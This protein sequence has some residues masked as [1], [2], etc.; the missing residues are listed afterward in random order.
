MSK[1]GLTLEIERK[2]LIRYPDINRLDAL[3]FKKSEI[4]QTY[5]VDEDEASS[6]RV[7]LRNTDGE[8]EYTKTIKKR[9]NNRSREEYEEILSKE[10]HESL[11][12]FK[13]PSLNV[14]KKK[15]WCIKEGDLVL[16]I[17]VFPFWTDRAFL[18]IELEREEQEIKIPS[19]IKII[20]E[21]TEDKRYTNRALS[22]QVPYDSIYVNPGDP[23]GN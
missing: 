10:E 8:I 17:D 16:E 18:E 20:K 9:I 19:Y 3:C 12:R 15:R 11:L 13:D 14:I 7:R 21:V 22:K 5:L 1:D 4:I 2:F 23:L 6:S